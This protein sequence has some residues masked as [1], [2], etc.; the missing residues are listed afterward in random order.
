M[1]SQSIRPIFVLK[2][3]KLE[4]R[5]AYSWNSDL[6]VNHGTT[7]AFVSFFYRK[8][9]CKCLGPNFIRVVE[10]WRDIHNL[11]FPFNSAK[12]GTFLCH[13]VPGRLLDD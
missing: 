5:P 9:L 6:R 2:C 7:I 13:L 1:R 8:N 4:I 3:V 12:A 11:P 10:K